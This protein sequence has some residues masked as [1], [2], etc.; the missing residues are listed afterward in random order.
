MPDFARIIEAHTPDG[1]PGK[2]TC[3]STSVSIF[4]QHSV[5]RRLFELIE[6]Q[7]KDRFGPET[8]MHRFR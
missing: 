6:S 8:T 7:I 2:S 4:R 3:T 1:I 5:L